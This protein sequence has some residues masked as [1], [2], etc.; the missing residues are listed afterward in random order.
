MGGILDSDGG[1]ISASGAAAPEDGKGLRASPSVCP[2]PWINYWPEDAEDH[3][4]FTG[5]ERPTTATA[6][7]MD[8]FY[9]LP[10]SSAEEHPDGGEA[11]P[12]TDTQGSS[13]PNRG[14][15][16]HCR[17]NSPSS[18]SIESSDEATK[19]SHTLQFQMAQHIWD[20]GPLGAQG[21][22]SMETV[23]DPQCQEGPVANII[24]S[25]TLAPD[26]EG[27]AYSSPSSSSCASSVRNSSHSEGLLYPY[28][29]C[30]SAGNFSLNPF[31]GEFSQP[32]FA[33]KVPIVDCGVTPNKT[34]DDHCIMAAAYQRWGP[35][36]MGPH[37]GPHEGGDAGFCDG[38]PMGMYPCPFGGCP[39]IGI[40]GGLDPL[41]FQTGFTMMIPPG[42]QDVKQE[43]KNIVRRSRYQLNRY[44]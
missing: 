13:S 31:A 1:C 11:M 30:R 3:G 40:P 14:V 8:A 16:K 38:G 10:P 28:S 17:F 33:Y 43:T 23:V 4:G 22:T 36:H 29:P 27:G 35:H 2:T 42:K 19:F 12:P 7:D 24:G 9:K 44:V 25:Y 39:K 5:Q 34:E 15:P 20:G 26:G 21:S 18:A 37:A 6:V 32:E 41:E